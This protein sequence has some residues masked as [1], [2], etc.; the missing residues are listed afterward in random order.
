MQYV[1]Q[2]INISAMYRLVLEKVMGLEADTTLEV[3]GQSLF[4]LK[5]HLGAIL[6]NALN[7]RAVIYECIGDMANATAYIDDRD[8]SRSE[9]EVI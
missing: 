6:Y 8:I 7:C 2:Q 4:C 1:A 3:S 5:N 9:R